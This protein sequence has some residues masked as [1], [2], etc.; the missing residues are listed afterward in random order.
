MRNI[1]APINSSFQSTKDSC[2]SGSS[3]QPHIQ[4]GPEGTGRSINTF[5]IV[6]ISIN[7]LGSSVDLMQLQFSEQLISK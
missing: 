5:H 3:S 4:E 2:P 6:L 7:L 1:Q